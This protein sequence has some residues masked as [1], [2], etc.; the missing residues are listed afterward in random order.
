MEFNYSKPTLE[1]LNLISPS[2]S[3]KDFSSVIS[4]LTQHN[5]YFLY[6]HLSQ[7]LLY[8]D[9]DE[10]KGIKMQETNSSYIKTL[11]N[12]KNPENES[13]CF[14]IDLKISEYYA[15]VL[16]LDNFNI[17]TKDLTIKNVSSSL[18][19]DIILCK[20]RLAIIFSNKKK[21]KEA[22]IEGEDVIRR[23]CDWDRRNKFKTYAGFFYVLN[24]K[25][26]QSSES[27]YNAL[28]TFKSTELISYG[29]CV[30]YLLFTSILSF[31]RV[32]LNDKILCN[33][34]VL[35]TLNVNSKGLALANCLYHCDYENLVNS[36]VN[37]AEEI[38]RDLYI[39]NQTDFFVR[40]VKIKIYKQLLESYKSLSVNVFCDILKVSEEYVERDLC[41]FIIDQRLNCV[42]DRCNRIV[43]VKEKID[44]TEEELVTKGEQLM[45][46]V[47]KN[48]K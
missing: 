45:R 1:I 5:M 42:I 37:F 43:E 11:I 44:M 28:A 16:D 14:E 19:M 2:I 17:L 18:K 13:E 40:E 22:F 34:D 6:K 30:F 29:K 23:G 36:L 21:T 7:D 26:V 12:E 27:F 46:L 3:T 15:S 8:F 41:D 10:R 31:D 24:K 9:Y 4:Y 20:M 35:E 48:L 25:H 47:Q 39:S 38:N 33:S 32:D